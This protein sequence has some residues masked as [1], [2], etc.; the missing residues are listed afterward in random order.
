M[1]AAYLEDLL[2]LRK[3]IPKAFSTLIQQE[4]MGII[5]DFFIKVSAGT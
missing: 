4:G 1:S 5:V 2:Y 3:H